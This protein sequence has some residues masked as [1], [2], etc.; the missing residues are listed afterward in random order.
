MST[1]SVLD[2]LDDR[3]LS[4]R[5]ESTITRYREVLDRLAADLDKDPLKATHND[6]RRYVV[7]WQADH[8]PNGAAFVLRH[9][10][11]FYRW[12]LEEQYITQDPTAGL[13]LKSQPAPML[14]ATD[15]DITKLLAVRG[16][17]QSDVRDRALLYL[18]VCTGARRSEIGR[19]TID[20]VLLDE[21]LV[22]I[23]R[24]KTVARY[25]PITQETA[26]HLRRWLRSRPTKCG[27]SLWAAS[28]GPALVGRVIAR[29]SCGALSPHSI[30][31][32]FATTWL[33]AGGSET[34]LARILGWTTSAMAAV[35][36]RATAQQVA[37]AEYRRV[38]D[39]RAHAG[40]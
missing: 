32:W 31:R 26:I 3:A 23:P 30:R 33:S 35:Y 28:D 37:H 12:A 2:F 22:M 29:R 6:L 18:I 8:T 14:T 1:D 16:R 36:T 24:S 39:G 25:V 10:K 21:L 40:G 20:D 19:L 9:L 17:S 27:N 34:S 13:K 15:D 38:F 4:G 11:A 5:R 7:A